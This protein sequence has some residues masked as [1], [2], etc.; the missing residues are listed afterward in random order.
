MATVL[1]VNFHK[2]KGTQTKYVEYGGDMWGKMCNFEAK[3][4]FTSK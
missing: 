2:K 1:T 3:Y 4:S